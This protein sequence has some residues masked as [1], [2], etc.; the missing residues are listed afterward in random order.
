V[1]SGKGKSLFEL[2]SLEQRILLS[3]DPLLGA[4]D[5]GAPEEPD[6][7]LTKE[8]GA[9]QVEEI[10]LSDEDLPQGQSPQRS[11]EYDPTA[12]L[13]DG[14]IHR[15]AACRSVPGH[16]VRLRLHASHPCFEHRR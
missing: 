15:L 8:P 7:L 13:S 14:R 16:F 9:P 4:V 12:G 1:A 10:Q 2:E 3:G 6:S 5:L 11:P